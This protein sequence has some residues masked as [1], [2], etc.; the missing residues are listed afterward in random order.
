MRAYPPLN[1]RV[2]SVSGGRDSRGRICPPPGR[3][4]LRPSPGD[5]LRYCRALYRK[6]SPLTYCRPLS[7]PNMA[8]TG[9]LSPSTKQVT[10]NGQSNI[11]SNQGTTSFFFQNLSLMITIKNKSPLSL[12]P[13]WFW[14]IAPAGCW[15]TKTVRLC[16]AF[17]SCSYYFL[18]ARNWK[19][20]RVPSHP[21]RN[22][23]KGIARHPRDPYCAFVLQTFAVGCACETG[24]MISTNLRQIKVRDDLVHC[25][26]WL[27]GV[28][29][30]FSR[31]H[32]LRSSGRLSRD[33]VWQWDQPP[34]AQSHHGRLGDY[35]LVERPHSHWLSLIRLLCVF[36]HGQ[37]AR[38]IFTCACIRRRTN[39]A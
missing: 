7:I 30:C 13:C 22:K 23:P 34:Q 29:D 18:A 28:L 36:M 15:G 20:W 35:R 14:E 39:Y 16:A 25:R 2:S 38:H 37:A 5:V 12:S 11:K 3:V 4:I 8:S 24:L 17:P 10:Y 6:V 32:W 9:Q 21:W 26:Q 33:C 27:K 31:H 1:F 19:I